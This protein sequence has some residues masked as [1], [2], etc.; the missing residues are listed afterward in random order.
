MCHAKSRQNMKRISLTLLTFVLT[1]SC[2]GQT[3]FFDNLENTTWLSVPNITDSIIKNSK[4]IPLGR[5]NLSKDSL[6]ENV[7]IWSF[8]DGLLTINYFD[9]KQKKET[10]LATFKYSADRN[11]GILTLYLGDQTQAYKVGITS[12]GNNATLIRQK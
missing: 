1:V 2:F 7:T 8:K 10:S 3:M 4:Q 11:K 12:T 5:M 9:I 6:K